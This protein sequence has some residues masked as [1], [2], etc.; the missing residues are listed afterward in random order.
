MLLQA[1]DW[2]PW[3]VFSAG[4]WTGHLEIRGKTVV[5]VSWVP[6]ASHLLHVSNPI[7]HPGTQSHPLG[8][9]LPPN[10]AVRREGEEK[11]HEVGEDLADPF[12]DKGFL[13]LQLW[14]Q[15]CRGRSHLL[16]LRD[17]STAQL[18]HPL[19]LLVTATGN[20]RWVSTTSDLVLWNFAAVYFCALSGVSAQQSSFTAFFLATSQD[21]RCSH[22]YNHFFI[23]Y[24]VKLCVLILA[25]I[26][27]LKFRNY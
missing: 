10:G 16:F 8:L 22:A 5:S 15:D 18:E 24:M 3:R 23:T 17:M 25:R 19:C 27:N 14:G 12:R 26:S 20:G 21:F 11:Q 9:N 1:G 6:P 7:C 13:V 4:L 2:N